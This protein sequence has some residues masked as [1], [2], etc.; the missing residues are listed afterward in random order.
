MKNLLPERKDFY[1]QL[2][3][4]RDGVNACQRT[5]GAQCLDIMGEVSKVPGPYKQ[6]EDNLDWMANDRRSPFFEDIYMLACRSHGPGGGV[7]SQVGNILEWADVLCDTINKA[8]GYRATAYHQFTAEQIAA[9]IDKGLPVMVSC[10]FG[11]YTDN[12]GKQRWKIPGHYISVVGYEDRED[13]RHFIIA[14]PYKNTLKN[15]PDGFGVRYSPKDWK[16]HYKGYGLRFFK[17]G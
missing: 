15:E 13:G 16:D 1:V 7:P 10:R 14:D 4:E 9:E 17:R 8:V 11:P 3:N 6:P 2:N 12:E 5:A